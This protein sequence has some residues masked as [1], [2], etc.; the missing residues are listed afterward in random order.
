VTT[1]CG[2]VAYEGQIIVVSEDE[3]A[4]GVV[5]KVRMLGAYEPGETGPA[6]LTKMLGHSEVCVCSRNATSVEEMSF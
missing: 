6:L 2:N 4:P 5:R 1:W 3:V